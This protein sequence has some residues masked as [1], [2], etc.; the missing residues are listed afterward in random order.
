MEHPAYGQVR[1][2]TPYASVLLAENPNIMTLHGTNTWLVSG[3]ESDESMVIDPGPADAEHLGRIADHGTVSLVLLTHHHPDHTEGVRD[4]VERTGAP[5]RALDPA[6]CARAEPFVDGEMIESAGVRLRVVATAGHTADSVCF[7][8]AHESVPAV[9]TGDSV[10][11]QG[12]TIVAHPDGHL[13]SYLASLRTLAALPPGTMGLPGHGP[14]LPDIASAASGYLDHRQKRLD[15]IR[16]VT[17]E[18][19]ADVTAREIVDV[20]YADIDSAA[21]PAA[22]ATVHAQLTYLREQ[23]EI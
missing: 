14:E 17:A 18:R 22:E 6:L 1:P 5:V 9:F 20:V 21:R 19:G 13:G 10:L 8:V 7:A 12:T 15:Q 23:R 4:L 16:A 11:G 2:V 3:P